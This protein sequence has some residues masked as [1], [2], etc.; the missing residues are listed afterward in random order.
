MTKPRDGHNQ[1]ALEL[2][3]EASDAREDL[4]ESP[5]NRLAILLVDDWPD[6]PSNTVVLAGPV[7]SGKSHIARVWAASSQARVV[8]AAALAEMAAC[9]W[10]GN[11]VVEDA[12]AGTLDEE[13]LFHVFNRLRSAGA[14]LL[15]TSREFP[16]GWGLALPDLASR[17]KTAH[18]V[19]LHEPDDALLA[20]AIVK[21]FAD[22]QVS[23]EPAVV[24][25]LVHRMERSL[26]AAS[27][28]VN[29]LDREALARRQRIS[30]QL[31]GEALAELGMN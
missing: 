8:E 16:A 23:I 14:F 5:A 15:I 31:A 29:W 20:G 19:E 3:L 1:L 27:R 10:T 26:E 9:E 18:L 24:S 11:L 6:W 17:M 2:P 12:G 21:L 25:Y 30:R 28:I 13:A 22:R 7:G 4:L